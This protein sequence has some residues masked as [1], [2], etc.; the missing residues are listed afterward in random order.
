MKKTNSC[1]TTLYTKSCRETRSLLVDRNQYVRSHKENN[2]QE[3]L[4]KRGRLRA[5]PCFADSASINL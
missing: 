3:C 5:Q 4:M 1:M 2:S